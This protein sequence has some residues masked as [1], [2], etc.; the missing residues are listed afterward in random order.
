MEMMDY[1][2]GSTSNV[3]IS[4]SAPLNFLREYRLGCH[5]ASLISPV[6]LLEEATNAWRALSLEEKCLFEEYSYLTARF[7]EP[8][9]LT[10]DVL[11]AQQTTVRRMPCASSTR[12]NHRRA[13]KTSK[14][15]CGM[16][17]LHRKK[18]QQKVPAASR[19]VRSVAKRPRCTTS[20]S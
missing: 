10:I 6:T 8:N 17:K 11:S 5:D 7:G 12:S 15:Q 19:K 9:R 18:R 1:C 3:F 4:R 14:L 2:M 13:F 16:A 20:K